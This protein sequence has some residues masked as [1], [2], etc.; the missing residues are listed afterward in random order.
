VV[1]SRQVIGFQTNSINMAHFMGLVFNTFT[2][3]RAQ[4]TLLIRAYLCD[5]GCE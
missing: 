5:G 4:K 3:K 1:I 2:N